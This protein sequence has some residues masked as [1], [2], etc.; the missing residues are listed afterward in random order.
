MAITKATIVTH[1]ELKMKGQNPNLPSDGDQS[2]E[3]IRFNT[4]RPSKSPDDLNTSPAPIANG[5]SK[6]KQRQ[7][8]IHFEDNA[9]INLRLVIVL[10]LSF[11]LV[12]LR[13]QIFVLSCVTTI[14]LLLCHSLVL[15]NLYATKRV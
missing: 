15:L 13:Y 7:T 12:L 2:E 9:S 6:K 11:G 4:E 1:K 10:V 14:E 5:N 3:N 8:T